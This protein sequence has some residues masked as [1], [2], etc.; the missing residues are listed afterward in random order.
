MYLK[1]FFGYKQINRIEKSV[2]PNQLA[3]E[4]PADLCVF[5]LFAKQDI[6]RFSMGRV[7]N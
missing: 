4:K 2:D 5:S 3:F 1:Q 6:S 7:K